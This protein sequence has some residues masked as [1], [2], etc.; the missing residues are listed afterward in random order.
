MKLSGGT[1]VVAKAKE[2]GVI[3]KKHSELELLEQFAFRDSE[4]KIGIGRK[5]LLEDEVV[6]YDDDW[7]RLFMYLMEL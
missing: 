7:S 6:F 5:G 4:G 1:Q 2:G 3:T